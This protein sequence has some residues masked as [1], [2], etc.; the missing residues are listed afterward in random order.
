MDRFGKFFNKITDTK[1]NPEDETQMAGNPR[2]MLADAV[3]PLLEE[4][5]NPVLPESVQLAIPKMTVADDKRYFENLPEQM[6]SS[7]TGR[8]GQVGPRFGK[9]IQ[10]GNQ[11]EQGL[12][13]VITKPNAADLYSDLHAIGQKKT[14]NAADISSKFDELYGAEAATRKAD[15][16]KGLLSPDA[17][18]SWKQEMVNK[19]RGQ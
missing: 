15:M 19:L 16:K 8:V 3:N 2:N 7:S 9:I 1:V 17:Y 18:S 11:A 14:L 13:K 4:Y 5:V 6:G 12:G 10:V